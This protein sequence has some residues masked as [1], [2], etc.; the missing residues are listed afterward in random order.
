MK[1]VEG[2]ANSHSIIRC[3]QQSSDKA[4]LQALGWP[5]LHDK[6]YPELQTESADDYTRPLQRLAKELRFIDPVTRE[7]RV[8]SGCSELKLG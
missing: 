7:V 3:L 8:F 4:L 2:E 5:I 6:Y 1:M